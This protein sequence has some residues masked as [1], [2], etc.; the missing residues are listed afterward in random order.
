M[1]IVFPPV[2]V[3]ILTALFI[4]ASVGAMVIID[5]IMA[6]IEF[7]KLRKTVPKHDD[8]PDGRSEFS[9]IDETGRMNRSNVIPMKRRITP[10]STGRQ[11]L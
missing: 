9:F 10:G 3:F 6:A 4:L 8:L 1:D 5:S 7:R 2:F 11:R